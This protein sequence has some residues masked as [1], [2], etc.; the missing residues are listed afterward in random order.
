MGA[1]TD[2]DR[3]DRPWTAQ[4]PPVH[5]PGA[6]SVQDLVI[7]DMVERKDYGLRKHG[8]TL[9][10]DN[11]RDALRDAYEESLDLACYLR[12]EIAR[13]DRQRA[14]HGAFPAIPGPG[15]VYAIIRPADPP[16]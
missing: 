4:P 7:A 3:T 8:T 2:H 12:Q 6:E 16:G 9:Q 15:E 5:V 13:R 1:T 14:L 10:V 11:G